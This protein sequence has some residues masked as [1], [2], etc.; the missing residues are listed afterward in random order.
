MKVDLKTPDCFAVR[1]PI[2]INQRKQLFG[3]GSSKKWGI[4]QFRNPIHFVCIR[5]IKGD[6]NIFIGIFDEDDAVAV[7][8]GTLPFAF[9]ENGAA[10]SGPRS[11]EGVLA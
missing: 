4:E 3:L 9:K 7:D 5:E 10:V 6:L 8:V 1:L 11:V 2:R